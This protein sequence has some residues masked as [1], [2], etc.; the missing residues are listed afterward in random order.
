VSIPKVMTTLYR[1]DDP[2]LL[3][4]VL[5]GEGVR[6]EPGAVLDG[7]TADRRTRNR[8][9]FRVLFRHPCNLRVLRAFF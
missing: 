6:L 5:S 3:T 7:L 1:A 9:A 2:N 4:S 8:T